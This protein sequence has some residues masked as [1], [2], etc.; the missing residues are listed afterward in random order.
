MNPKTPLTRSATMPL[1]PVIVESPYSGD[2]TLHLAYLRAC[3]R[4][5]LARGESPYASHGLLTQPGV[6]DD[7]D[8]HD[9]TAGFA[10]G[11]AWRLLAAR[12]VFYVD[13]G[14]SAGMDAGLRDARYHCAPTVERVL[15]AE[16]MA[17]IRA[18]VAR[19]DSVCTHGVHCPLCLT[20]QLDAAR[21]RLALAQRVIDL[22]DTFMLSAD[23]RTSEVLSAAR[24]EWDRGET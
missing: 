12:T 17:R 5:C 1:T 15:G 8:P 3:L 7:A 18:G 23:S 22:T 10:A 14:W 19:D 20:A 11:F 24:A 21:A 6:L 2:T 13:L 16:A 9:R 4:D